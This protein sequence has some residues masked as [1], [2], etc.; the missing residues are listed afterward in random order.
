LSL[1]YTA[2]GE[3]S[4]NYNV[5][6]ACGIG[7][8][9]GLIGEDRLACG[10]GEGS[11]LIGEDRLACGIGEGSGLIGEDR[12]ACGI[13]EGSGLIGEA[14]ARGAANERTAAAMAKLGWFLMGGCPFLAQMCAI[15]T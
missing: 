8:G 6:L 10:I 15:K 7:E 11:G 13:G 1:L 14:M 5:N 12:F 3:N 2:S 9:N 4:S